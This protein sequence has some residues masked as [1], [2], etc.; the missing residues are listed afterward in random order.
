MLSLYHRNFLE[1]ND[2]SPDELRLIL[3]QAQR[4]K[5]MQKRGEPHR[6]LEGKTLAMIFEKHSTRTRTSFE[7]GM[8]QLGG[9]AV[10]L[11]SEATQMGRGEP[12][13]DTARVLSGYVDV[14][15]ARVYEHST[16][17]GL[18]KYAKVPVINGLSDLEHPVQIL[19]DLQTILEEKGK[20]EGLKVAYIGDGNNVANSLMIGCAKAGM[21]FSI[22]C[23]EG[24]EPDKKL[25]ELAKKIAAEQ[26]GSVEIT[27][28]PKTAAKQADALYTDVWVSMGQE[29][30]S[31][32][33]LKAFKSYQVNAALLSVANKGCI[34]LHDLPAHRGEEISVDA[35][36]GP[37]SRVFQEAENRLHAQKA[38]LTLLLKKN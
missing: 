2:V 14:I 13:E 7:V 23:P 37:Q 9:H 33:R 3:E 8:F 31:Q 30:E 34:V 25:T 20:L 19:A 35:I 22:A 24:Y 16:V 12:L 32:K 6:L 5:A 21:H 27:R 11:S 36:E 10:F 29:E 15:M 28:D 26:H 17:T 1:M 18:A 4:L 38:L